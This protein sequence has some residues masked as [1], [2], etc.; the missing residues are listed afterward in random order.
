[1]GDGADTGHM[2]PLA[3]RYDSR[4]GRFGRVLG[5]DKHL[6]RDAGAD[7]ELEPFDLGREM[8]MQELRQRIA[9]HDYRVDPDAVAD[10]IVARL[11]AGTCRHESQD[12]DAQC[13]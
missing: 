13:S 1:M 5:G 12:R 3:L 7:P 8:K 2:T 4:R 10:A 11:I 6:V 9:S